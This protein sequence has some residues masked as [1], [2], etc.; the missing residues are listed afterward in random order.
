MNFPKLDIFNKYNQT[1]LPRPQPSDIAVNL[2]NHMENG[3]FVDIGANDGLSCNNSLVF[4]EGYNWKGICIE[5]HPI[6]FNKLINFRKK[7]NCFNIGL[8]NENG[9]LEFWSVNGAAQCISGFNKFFSDSHRER[10]LNEVERNNDILEKIP[11]QIK[12]TSDFFKEQNIK[13][14]NYL[15]IDAEGADFEILKGI[16][17]DEVHITLISVE[18]DHS[19]DEVNQ[20]LIEN[21]FTYVTKC[22][23]DNFFANNKNIL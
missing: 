17:F 15:S 1:H 11:V 10:L 12:K 5:P 19:L 3:F 20:F 16:N 18:A 13:K 4:E 7:E 9:N 2:L 23:G 22:C 21:K 6:I 14:I 8:G